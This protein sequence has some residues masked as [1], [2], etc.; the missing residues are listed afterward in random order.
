MCSTCLSHYEIHTMTP[1]IDALVMTKFDCLMKIIMSNVSESTEKLTSERKC[2]AIALFRHEI[3]CACHS[4]G[5]CIKNIN[6]AV[7]LSACGASK[8]A[9]IAVIIGT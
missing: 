5:I 4:T 9:K 6:S 3:F 7:R 8:C 1:F 2:A